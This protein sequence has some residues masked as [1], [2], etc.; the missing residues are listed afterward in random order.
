MFAFFLLAA[1]IGVVYLMF[2]MVQNDGA[3]R[4]EDQRGLLRMA[5]PKRV[6]ATA[7]EN[8]EPPRRGSR[9]VHPP[10]VRV[11][12][13]APQAPPVSKPVM[14]RKATEVAAEETIVHPLFQGRRPGRRP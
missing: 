6:V 9:I 2:W 4:I 13:R 7:E 3:D 14:G 8:P 12:D 5:L 11:Q 10:K 1:L